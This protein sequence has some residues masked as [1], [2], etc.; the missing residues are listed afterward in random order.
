MR[1][2][3]WFLNAISGL[4]ISLVW[5]SRAVLLLTLIILWLLCSQ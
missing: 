2:P 3:V 4:Y 5:Y 1:L